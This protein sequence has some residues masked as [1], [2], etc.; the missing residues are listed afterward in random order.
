MIASPTAMEE[1]LLVEMTVLFQF[2]PIPFIAEVAWSECFFKTKQ[3]EIRCGLRFRSILDVDLLYI[4]HFLY[5]Q[6]LP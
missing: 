1:G 6:R 4:Q 2:N 5:K 3:K